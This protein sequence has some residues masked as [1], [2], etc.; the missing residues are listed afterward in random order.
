MKNPKLTFAT[1]WGCLLLLCAGCNAPTQDYSA[2]MDTMTFEWSGPLMEGSNPAQQIVQVNLQQLLG[3]RFRDDLEI[4]QVHL[5]SAVLSGD[6]G[7][8]MEQLNSLVLSIAG[9]DPALPMK[10]L[11]VLNPVQISQGKAELIPSPEAELKDFFGQ[12]QFYLVVDAGLKED[13]DLDLRLQGDFR[14]KIQY[15]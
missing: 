12:K 2:T 14:W 4:V 9:D 6:S 5:E 8:H 11:A 3:D 7:Q 15:R 13:R 1:L 10:E